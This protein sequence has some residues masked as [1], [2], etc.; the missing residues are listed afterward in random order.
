MDN[1]RIK[2]IRYETSG[3]SMNFHSEF[4]LEASAGEVIRT[5][6]WK[7]FF[8]GR[9]EENTPHEKLQE[10]DNRYRTSPDSEDLI[11]REH[12]PMDGDLWNVLAEEMEYLREQLSPVKN[13][14]VWKPISDVHVLDGGDYTRLYIT[15]DNDG[16]E[17]TVQYYSPSGKRWSTVIA[18]LHEMAHPLGR[19]LRRIGETQLTEMFLKAPDYSYQITPIQGGCDYYFFVHGDKS[20]INKISQEQWKPVRDFL[21]HVDLSGFGQ[22]KYECKYYLRLNYNDGINRN[23][24][25]NKKTAGMIREFLQH[26]FEETN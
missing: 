5:S 22:G 16:K 17:N 8:F 15:W 12:I 25:I 9:V 11:V 6:Y 14:P 20:P 19:D 7:D 10:I 24:E 18:V 3:G 23:L 26:C 1:G 13:K 2:R 21:N 4:E